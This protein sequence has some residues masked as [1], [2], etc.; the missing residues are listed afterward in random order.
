MCS[1]TCIIVVVMIYRVD[2]LIHGLHK[3]ECSKSSAHMYTLLKSSHV[4]YN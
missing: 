1:T 2:V 4:N 3:D